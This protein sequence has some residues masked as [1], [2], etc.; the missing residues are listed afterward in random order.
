MIEFSVNN[1]KI[2]IHYN[3]TNK[4][5][6]DVVIL[7]TFGGEGE[8][9]FN[10][11]IEIG[12]KDFILVSISNIDWNNELTPWECMPIYKGDNG[13]LGKADV[14]LN[15]LQED[16]IPRIEECI[17]NKLNK[18]I[19]FYVL[20]GYSLAGLFAIYTGY[21]TNTFKRL[22]SVSGSLWYPG[23]L[24]FIK[25]NKLKSDVCKVY[26]SL[27]NKESDTKNQLLSSV[28]NN[29]SE[30]HKI[31]DKSVE[32]IFEMNDGNHFKDETLRIAKSIKW[33]LK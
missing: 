29:T 33:I 13:Y 16:I 24:D 2:N 6:L 27:G 28:E 17:T 10:K 7:N 22:A 5:E 19:S 30:I 32:S 8:K 21:R 14:Y 9:V 23:F 1:K 4:S 20:C 12:C 3:Q 15:E 31:V 26:L 25:N 11:C 18:D